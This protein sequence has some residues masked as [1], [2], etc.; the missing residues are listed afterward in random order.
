MKPLLV[1]KL[2]EE[3]IHLKLEITRLRGVSINHL[4]VAGRWWRELSRSPGR[5]TQSGCRQQRGRSVT[6]KGRKRCLRCNDP[7]HTGEKCPHFHY[8]TGHPCNICGLL[9]ETKAHK[10]R[11]GSARRNPSHREVQSHQAE[12]SVTQTN[13]SYE[14]GPNVFKNSGYEN[15]FGKKN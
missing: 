3:E 8:Y 12:E 13:E 5:R 15:I 1:E 7:S 11:S 4:V 14:Q 6:P 9:H 2:K 10:D